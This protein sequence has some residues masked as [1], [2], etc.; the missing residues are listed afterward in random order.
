MKTRANVKTQIQRE[1]KAEFLAAIADKYGG[2]SDFF[3]KKIDELC[4]VEKDDKPEETDESKKGFIS[5]NVTVTPEQ[6]AALLA[7]C[8]KEGVTMGTWMRN[9]I[10]EYLSRKEENK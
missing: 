3:Q 9:Q 4:D 10:K 7:Q 1:L 5:L 2:A 8:E 6:R